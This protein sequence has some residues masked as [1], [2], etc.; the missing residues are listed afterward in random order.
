MTLIRKFFALCALLLLLAGGASAWAA[1][2]RVSSPAMQHS[3][4]ASMGHA[5]CDEAGGGMACCDSDHLCS[6]DCALSHCS[7]PVALTLDGTSFLPVA[8]IQSAPAYRSVRFTSL[9]LPPQT[10]PP[11]C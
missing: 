5:C 11:T 3:A 9:T 8:F 1:S 4:N 6:T 7:A 10:P 2:D